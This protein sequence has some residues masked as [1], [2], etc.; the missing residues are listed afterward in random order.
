[1]FTPLFALGRVPGWAAHY[2]EQ[3]ADAKARIG[4]PR[5]IYTGENEKFL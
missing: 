1:M 2:T 5:Q 4:R 3:H